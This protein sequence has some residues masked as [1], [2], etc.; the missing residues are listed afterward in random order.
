MRSLDHSAR[1]RENRSRLLVPVALSSPGAVISPLPKTEKFW[2]WEVSNISPFLLVCDRS[3]LWMWTGKNAFFLKA[4]KVYKGCKGLLNRLKYVE[5]VYLIWIFTDVACF[6][7]NTLSWMLRSSQNN[8]RSF[9]QKRMVFKCALSL[10]R[11]QQWPTFLCLF[12]KS[13]S[14]FYCKA[15]FFF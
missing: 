1:E 4:S 3:S 10:R 6:I 9:R 8:D 7:A 5:Y 11:A 15:N 2:T 14:L 13:R 12:C